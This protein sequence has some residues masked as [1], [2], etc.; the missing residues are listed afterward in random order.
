MKTAVR[1][2][3]IHDNQLLVMHRNKFGHQYYTLPGGGVRSGE[4]NEQALIRELTEETSIQVSGPRL[5]FTENPGPPYGEQYIYLCDYKSGEPTLHPGSEE[6]KI[7]AL[8]QNIY[9]PQWLSLNKLA[10]VPFLSV[11]LRDAI[12]ES[13]KTTF[14]EQAHAV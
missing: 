6:A 1:A 11:R 14:P 10:D 7:N 12:L 13:V 5:V 2:I 8:G 4:G 9:T 3:V